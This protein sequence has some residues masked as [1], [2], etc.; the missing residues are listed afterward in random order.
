MRPFV[1]LSQYQ[2]FLAVVPTFKTLSRRGHIPLWHHQL[3]HFLIGD[4]PENVIIF[5]NNISQTKTRVCLN[6][7]FYY[8]EASKWGKV[9]KS[10]YI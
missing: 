2:T 6:R 10:V 7:P 5:F 4:G 9:L 3:M 8:F 1:L